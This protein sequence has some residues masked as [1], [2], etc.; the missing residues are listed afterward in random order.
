MT[1]KVEVGLH[2]LGNKIDA[3]ERRVME[4]NGSIGLLNKEM[5]DRVEFT[6]ERHEGN[7]KE[8]REMFAQIRELALLRAEQRVETIRAKK[9]KARI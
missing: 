4:Q 3:V 6:R 7:M 8:H 9:R 5:K 1:V 2:Q